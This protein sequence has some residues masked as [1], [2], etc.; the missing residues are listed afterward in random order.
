M[1]ELIRRDAIK[2]AIAGRDDK[3]LD[4]LIRFLARLVDLVM[5][6]SL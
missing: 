6:L 5:T 1:E 3:S 2:P 4:T